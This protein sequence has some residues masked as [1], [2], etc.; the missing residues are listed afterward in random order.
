[1]A[2]S[3]ASNSSDS[4]RR[5]FLVHGLRAV[6]GVAAASILFPQRLPARMH[7]EAKES[8][9][10]FGFTTYTWG[11]DWDLPTMLENLQRAEVFG[12]ELRTSLGYA[13]GVELELDADRRRE[14]RQ[15]FA[16]S[17]VELVGLASGERMDWPDPARLRAAID[18]AKAHVKLSHDVGSSGVRVFPDQFHA[19]VSREKTIAQ[20]ARS[21]NEIGVFAADYGQEIRLEAHGS[22][23]E[24]TSIAAI[25]DQVDQPRVRVKLNSDIR[26]AAEFEER[27]NR[28]KDRLARTLHIH[29]LTDPRFPYQ[30]QTDLLVRAGWDGWALLEVSHQVPDRVQAIIEQRKIWEQMV[31][32]AQAAR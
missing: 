3:Q 17:P 10:R 15:R 26:D 31:A 2:G 25:M 27:F 11:R 28:V 23:G 32:T 6:T 5:E 16:D 22:A 30:L 29:N 1:M 13:H 18:G 21:L 19:D 20:I 12:A 14:V 9:L 7:G 8:R 24:L 4:T